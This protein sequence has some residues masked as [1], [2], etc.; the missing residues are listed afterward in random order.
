MAHTLTNYNGVQIVTPDNDLSAD[1]QA[2]NG[3]FE[4]LADHAFVA[5]ATATDTSGNSVTVCNGT[6]AIT[7]TGKLVLNGQVQIHHNG[8]APLP[9]P[10][11][12]AALVYDT[13]NY[14]VNA[15]FNL[16]PFSGFTSPIAA[17]LGLTSGLGYYGG[18]IL[19]IDT[20]GNGWTFV[21][22][23]SGSKNASVGAGILAS[24]FGLAVDPSGNL[25][26]YGNLTVSG[27][28]NLDGGAIT[29]DGSGDLAIA[30]TSGSGTALSVSGGATSL[31]EGGIITDGSGDL[32][33]AP[34]SGSGTA[35]SVS[36]GAT[37][38]DAGGII[39]DGSGNI[40]QCTSINL[41]N[42]AS[43]TFTSADGKTITVTNGI[44]TGIM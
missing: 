1:R 9:C 24:P 3:N 11:S 42:G 10:D 20:S 7:A 23:A 35:L 8:T 41:G 15:W 18:M 14:A 4:F 37:S 22:G 30:P 2:L 13:A 6:S 27:A 29:T 43:G 39:T 38:L 33:I 40:T 26:E 5:G 17:T 36:G 12:N 32:A 19:L 25:L 21:V 28:T 34:T 16:P 31:D 44:I